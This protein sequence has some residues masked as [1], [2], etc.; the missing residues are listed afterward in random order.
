MRRTIRKIFLLEGETV[1]MQILFTR[2][3]EPP[4]CAEQCAGD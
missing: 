2:Q 3:N 1:T 4:S